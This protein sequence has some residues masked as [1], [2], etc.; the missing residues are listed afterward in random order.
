[1]GKESAKRMIAA[2]AAEVQADLVVMGTIP[3]TGVSGL[4]TGNTAETILSQLSCSVLAI[5]PPGFTTPVKI[6][7]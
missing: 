4:I 1:V 7:G 3:R 5:K 6:S 2:L